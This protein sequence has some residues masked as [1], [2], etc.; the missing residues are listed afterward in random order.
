MIGGGGG[1]QFSLGYFIWIHQ[2]IWQEIGIKPGPLFGK[3]K[4]RKTVEF[5][6]KT[7]KPEDFVGIN[8]GIYIIK[9]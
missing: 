6:G 3:L 1:C 7:L 9:K 2:F 8:V 5:E 4:Q